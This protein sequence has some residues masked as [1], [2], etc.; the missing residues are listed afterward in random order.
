ML[1]RSV[2]ERVVVRWRELEFEGTPPEP[3]AFEDD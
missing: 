1:R 2:Y 3:A